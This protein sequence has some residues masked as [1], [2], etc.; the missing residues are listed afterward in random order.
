LKNS[1]SA[2]SSD[3]APKPLLWIKDWNFYW[4]DSYVYGEPVRLPKGTL[5]E[6]EAWY[7]NSADN[8]ANPRTPPQRV[9]FGNNTT[10]EMCFALFQAVTDQPGAMREMGRSMMQSMMQEWNT[11]PL[12]PEARAQIMGEAMKLFRGGR[13]QRPQAGRGADKKSGVDAP[14]DS[15]K[16]AQ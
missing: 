4:Q 1:G 8:P 9:L 3:G 14:A 7:D 16:A 10:D 11:A 12:S 13:R 5:L 6:I 15:N 2:R